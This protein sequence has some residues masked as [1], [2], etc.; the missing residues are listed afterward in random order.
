MI[1]KISLQDTQQF[2]SSF[3]DYIEQK[4]ELSAFYKYTPDLDGFA[5][6]I[7]H[8]KFES[9]KR[10]TLCTVLKSQYAAIK[11]GKNVISNIDLLKEQHT[12]TITTGHQL[13]IFTG[14]LYFIYKIL[15]TINLAK[16][17]GEIYF[18]K[19]FVPIYWMATEDHD[20]EEINNMILFGKNYTWNSDQKGAVGRFNLDGLD[21]I[22]NQ[23]KD[24]PSYF[25]D[26]Y[27]QHTNLADATR[28][29]VNE[30]FGKYGL[31][32]L[33]ADNSVLKKE[34]ASII[35]DELLNQ[36]ASKTV[37]ATNIKLE[38]QG[39]SSQAHVRDI[40]LFYL[41]GNLRERI[42]LE[43]GIYK[44]LHTDITFS[45]VEIE[46]EVDNNPQ[47]F[48][49][50]VILR[51]L[52]QE[53]VLPNLA[54]IGGPSEIIYWL[55]LKDLFDL[56]RMDFP[57][58]IP[59]NFGLYASKN[60][61]EKTTKLQLNLIDYFQK[62]DVL[63]HKILLNLGA[64][65]ITLATQKTSI[66][67]AFASIISDA[68]FVDKSLEGYI[69]AEENNV[70]KIIAEIEKKITKAEERKSETQINQA[71]NIQEKLFPNGNLQERTDNFLNFAINNPQ[72]IDEMIP[73]FDP[74]D[75]RFNI[76]SA[77]E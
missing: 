55:Q 73:Y 72:F 11:C 46:K 71:F 54:Y 27:T 38:A 33:D 49:P 13:N 65:V 57:I 69:K 1:Q 8:Y 21:E 26:A 56:Y 58:L 10:E 74:L 14:P 66:E 7:A 76:I 75:F 5:S 22:V 42:V 60:Q 25:K 62:P 6:K 34:F 3:I 45:K 52:Y 47:Y 48:S 41:N 63:K 61:I 31:V 67:K 23:I 70:M 64:H 4:K 32:V 29:F 44:V 36:T 18:D 59:R 19:K 12:Y 53:V 9:D 39:Y 77:D 35:K 16:Q 15:S 40:N 17:L 43:E 68:N 50:N 30:I 37:V 24:L 51:P 2:S 28:Y 20:F